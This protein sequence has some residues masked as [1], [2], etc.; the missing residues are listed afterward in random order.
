MDPEN[1]IVVDGSTGYLDEGIFSR[2]SFAIRLIDD[3]TQ[4]EP[5]GSIRLTIKGGNEKLIQERYRKPV[6]NPSGYYIFTDL[7]D[8]IY[9][10]DIESDY[11]FPERN[12]EVSTSE[13]QAR[14]L[15]FETTGPKADATSTRLK[16]VSGLRTGYVVEFR[17]QDGKIE[18]RS[19]IA[20]KD[21]AIFWTEPLE[22]DFSL[23]GSSVRTSYVLEIVLKPNPVYP[24]PDATTLIRGTVSGIEAGDPPALIR[25][26]DGA[27]ETKTYRRGDFALYLKGIK[28]KEITV[29]IIRKD[30]NPQIKTL[31]IKDGE[32]ISLRKI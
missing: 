26:K 9:A 15:K 16:D 12:K 11:Y 8:K 5:I 14:E 25:I 1:P 21:S 17:N 13:I 3:F 30:Q 23:D 29:E 10:I 7:P 4:G 28:E 27:E 18:D 31:R 2:L 20:I 22:Y 24:F 6:K 19:I 32:K